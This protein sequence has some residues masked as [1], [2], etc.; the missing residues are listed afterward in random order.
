M[1][2]LAIP[3]IE[4]RSSAAREP[5]LARPLAIPHSID[6]IDGIPYYD[7]EFAMAQSDAH[8]R[9]IYFLGALLD[10]VAKIAGLRG[11]SDYPIWY[12]FPEQQQQKALYPDFALTTN[13]DIR[14]L[15]ARDLLWT[16]EV[17]TTSKPAKAYKDTVRMRDYNA[18]HGVPEFVL[19]FP[20]LDDP[21]SVV[22]HRYDA[23]TGHYQLVALPADR[24]YRSQAIPGLEIEVL[25]PA[26][27]TEERKV[28]VYFRGEELRE[29]ADEARARQAAEQQA[30]QERQA[31]QI[32]E[33]QARREQQARQAAEQQALQ[34]L[35]ARQVAEQQARQESQARQAAE[36][37]VERLLAML[38]QAGLNPD[39]HRLQ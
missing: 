6:A 10:R 19:V 33:K 26:E 24:R 12:W 21:R 37:Q 13:T 9:T 8:R 5:L 27:W 30:R 14:A 2:T 35:Q 20:E 32:A 34:E 18:V 39:D 31:R 1:T 38:K 3:K 15:T 4:L 7:E 22:W 29:G 16:M 28:R 23:Q 25:D 36:Q 17:V 11:V